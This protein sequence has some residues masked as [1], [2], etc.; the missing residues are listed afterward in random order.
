[1]V[2]AMFG[3]QLMTSDDPALFTNHAKIDNNPDKLSE[4]AFT[5]ELIEWYK[6][7]EGK[8]FGIERNPGRTRGLYDFFSR[9]GSI[10]SRD[11]SIFGSINLSD[12]EQL[13]FAELSE[14]SELT[15]LTESSES[16]ES[17][18]PDLSSKFPM[19]RHSM[20]IFGL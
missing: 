12:R 17:V 4:A 6:H 3:S 19:P 9:D 7:I 16:F 10:F 18:A 1:M 15:R 11:G 2:A 8:E 20:I 13:I 14:P 5:R